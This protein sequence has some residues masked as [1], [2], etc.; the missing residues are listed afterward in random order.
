MVEHIY[1]RML[2]LSVRL[3]YGRI[4]GYL[5]G[6]TQENL[7]RGARPIFD[8]LELLITNTSAKKGSNVTLYHDNGRG[9][10]VVEP[11]T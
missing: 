4:L 3:S 9:M 6:D 11:L 2:S 1:S 5:P 8:N 7:R 10:L